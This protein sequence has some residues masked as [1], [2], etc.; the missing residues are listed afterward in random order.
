MKILYTS[1]IAILLFSC[2]PDAFEVFENPVNKEDIKI[3]KLRSDNDKLLA[4]NES[5]MEFRVI[6]YGIKEIKEKYK[7][8]IGDNITYYDSIRIDTFIIPETQ[9]PEGLIKVYDEQG[10]VIE[11]NQFKTSNANS[12]EIEFYAKA[13]NLQSNTLS[14]KIRDVPNE[15]YDELEIPIIFHVLQPPS[16]TA[17]TTELTSEIVQ[18]KLD[19]LNVIYNGQRTTNPN[20]GHAKITFKLAKYDKNG[21]LLTQEGLNVVNID[22]KFSANESFE[23]MQNNLM[24]DPNKYLNIWIYDIAQGEWISDGSKSFK[25]ERPAVILQGANSIPGIDAQEVADYSLSDVTEL[26]D[27]GIVY[28]KSDFL[29]NARGLGSTGFELSRIM[30]QYLGLY[31]MEIDIREYFDYD[32][33][34]WVTINNFIDGDT[35]FCEDTSPY[36]YTA[37]LYKKDAI[38]GNYF[39]TFNIM[40]DF[41]RKNSITVDQ[42]KRI[43][44]ILERCP[45]RWS[46]KS[47]WALT[48]Q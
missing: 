39:T 15:N 23:Y 1:I 31:T 12:A 45:S 16:Y 46:Y 17:P 19:L 37:S 47:S 32:I 5:I 11:N 38:T 42:A 4:N 36:D 25:V 44:D 33:Y 28:N 21:A 20:V 6:A 3:I 29:R 35:D 7:E 24:W 43:R 10:T 9:Y 26:T 2:T 48:G 34:D 14:V 41:S 8:Q 18:E 22:E 40:A 30:G 27:I 13:D